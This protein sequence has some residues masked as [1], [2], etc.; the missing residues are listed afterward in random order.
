M[1]YK[2]RVLDAKCYKT[3]QDEVDHLLK[4][5]FIRE[6]YYPGWLT[7]PILVIKPNGKWMTCIDFMNL[8]KAC[9]EDSF[10]LPRIN[11]LVDTTA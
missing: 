4:I 5:G 3:L 1:C 11:Q 7:D 8:N 2:Q 9:P 6:S 10:L